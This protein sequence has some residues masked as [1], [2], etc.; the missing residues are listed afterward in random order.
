MLELIDESQRVPDGGEEDVSARLVGL[1]LDGES[2]LVA[3]VDDIPGEEVERLIVAIEGGADILCGAGLGALA[4]SPEDHDLR[5][6]LSGEIEV[7]QHLAER[8]AAHLA[9]I[10]CEATIAE[11]WVRKEVG[12]HHGDHQPSAFDRLAQ[13]SYRM[14]L[15]GRRGAERE[16]VVVVEAHPIGPQFGKPGHRHHRVQRRAHGAAED[17]DPLP[18]HRPE[19]ERKEVFAARLKHA[20]FPLGASSNHQVVQGVNNRLLFVWITYRSEEHTSELQSLRHLVC[21]LLLEKR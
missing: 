13:T 19:S 17:V 8:K 4:P 12:G 11:D 15:L 7:V 6:E 21:R 2:E 20:L 16:D 9:V 1:R 5:T 10:G 18:A 3:V 14:A